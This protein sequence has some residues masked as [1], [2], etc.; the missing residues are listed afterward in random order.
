VEVVSIISDNELTGDQQKNS[1]VYELKYGEYNCQIGEQNVSIKLRPTPSGTSQCGGDDIFTLSVY[2]DGNLVKSFE[3]FA[4]SC[5]NPSPHIVTYKLR[6]ELAACA[7]YA[8]RECRVYTFRNG[9][10]RESLQTK[11]LNKPLICPKEKCN[12]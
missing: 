8:R 9:K 10:I 3:K 6:T 5:W 1:G 4:A 7:G 2:N 11:R 12:D